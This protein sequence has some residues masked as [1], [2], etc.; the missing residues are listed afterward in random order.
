[1]SGG[2]EKPNP[3]K[4]WPVAQPL[5]GPIPVGRWDCIPD[6]DYARMRES[7]NSFFPGVCYL[8]SI[9]E[10]GNEVLPDGTGWTLQ[11]HKWSASFIPESAFA[12]DGSDLLYIRRDEFRWPY[13]SNASTLLIQ[14]RQNRTWEVV[15]VSDNV[16][17]ATRNRTTYLLFSIGSAEHQRILKFGEYVDDN[18]GRNLFDVEDCGE[19]PDTG[20]G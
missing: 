19:P 17:R 2:G 10:R 7:N 3:I 8:V 11:A 4:T 1:M 18:R 14:T 20:R 16:F 12:I 6:A 5:E 13:D 9:G 15:V